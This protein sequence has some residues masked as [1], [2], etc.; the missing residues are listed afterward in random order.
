MKILIYGAGIVGTTYG[1]Q[2]SQAGHEVSVLVK[3]EKKQTVEN[4]GIY[5]HCTDFRE[6]KRQVI[7]TVF[8][9]QVIDKLSSENEYEFIIVTVNNIQL[10]QVL[11]VLSQ[12]AGKANIL[13]FQNNW[14]SFDEIA[15]YLAP[16]QYFFG[17]PF[18][19]GGGMNEKGINCAISGLK[20]S[21]TPIGELNG[22]LTPRVEKIVKALEEA[23]LK[24][25]V[26]KHIKEWLITHYAVATGLSTGIMKAGSAVNFTK[27]TAII[28]EAIKAIREGLNV[29]RERG[30]NP[31]DEKSNS[32][33]YLPLFIGAVI[34]KKIYSNEALQLMFDGHT[35]HSPEE[36]QK[37]ISDILEKGK[38]FG[39]E[40][41]ILNNLQKTMEIKLK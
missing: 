5:L 22:E 32:L 40:T 39:V 24:P 38:Q 16:E 27:N 20:Y 37:M 26:S 21:H 11:P 14:D 36:V 8:R 23:N 13:F 9:P 2:L 25:V 17:F 1:W 15:N 30:I 3:K 28:K 41:P 29:C 4:S 31:K 12:S 18:M 7:E 6:N 34:A 33:Y 10:Q 19:V 35:K